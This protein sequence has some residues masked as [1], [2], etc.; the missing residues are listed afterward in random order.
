MGTLRL[1]RGL[2]WEVENIGSDNN[3]GC[4]T[5]WEMQRKLILRR[6]RRRKENFRVLRPFGP[7]LGPNQRC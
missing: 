1:T 5:F 4:V 2:L 3:E 6:Q 7:A